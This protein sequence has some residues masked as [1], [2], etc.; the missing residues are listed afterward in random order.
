M[1]PESGSVSAASAS[2]RYPGPRPFQQ[3][4]SPLFFGREG[5]I[6]DLHTLVMIYRTVLLYAKSGVG[7]TSL[8]DAGLAPRLPV[9][10]YNVLRARVSGSIP[11]GDQNIYVF[12]T[13]SSVLGTGVATE[14]L[15]AKGLRD[16]VVKNQQH[17]TILVIFDQFE[18]F[19]TAYPEK[20]QHRRAFFEEPR[21]MVDEQ[22][23][24][25]LLFSLREE[26]LGELDMYSEYVPEEFRIRY[27][28][29][30]LRTE[31]A[32]EAIEKPIQSSGRWFGKGVA[33]EI[34]TDLSKER[35]QTRVGHKGKGPSKDFIGEFV[36]PLHL[37][38]V[39]RKLWEG[40]NQEGHTG[41][42]TTEQFKRLGGPQPPENKGD[43]ASVVDQALGAFYGD[44]VRVVVSES[45]TRRSR[46]WR[47]VDG[48]TEM[49]ESKLRHWFEHQ[50][51]TTTGIRGLVFEGAATAAGIP[52]HALDRLKDKYIVRAEKRAGGVWYELTHD[53]FIEPIQ[54]SS[55]KYLKF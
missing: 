31:A 13:V 3:N 53:R 26:H 29:E 21:T 36:E 17:R 44:A 38:L 43:L 24:V 45:R 22:P 16:L 10:E 12:N 42:I 23:D 33:N 1:G 2:E 30:R 8:I 47:W 9:E 27:H 54:N 41:E 11:L 20:W 18:E 4:E 14:G 19:F 40:L 32:K 35:I 51:I 55:Q 46:A 25:R 48:V 50:L 52:D 39:C 28:L 37:Q 6:A 15:L 34:V 7:K 49:T 5:E